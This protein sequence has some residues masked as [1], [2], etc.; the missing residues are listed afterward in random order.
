V[1]ETK[2]DVEYFHVL[3][4]EHEIMFTEGLPTESFHPGEYAL[5]EM[6]EAARNELLTLFPEFMAQKGLPSTARM[7]LRPW[8]GRLLQG[9]LAEGTAAESRVAS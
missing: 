5:R 2:K 8:E 6:D 1:D 9:T 4:D 7:V 3:F